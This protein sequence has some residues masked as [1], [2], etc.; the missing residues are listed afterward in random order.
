MVIT[1]VFVGGRD[2]GCLLDISS[3]NTQRC[4]ELLKNVDFWVGFNLPDHGQES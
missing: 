2:K 1:G 3:G 4:L